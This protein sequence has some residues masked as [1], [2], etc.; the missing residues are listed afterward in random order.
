M[1]IAFV[2]DAVYPWVKGGVERRIYELGRR[3]SRRHEVH[4]FS[5]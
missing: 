4:W 1:R 3:L 2:Y 5:L